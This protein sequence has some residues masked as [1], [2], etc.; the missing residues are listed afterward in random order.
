[1]ESLVDITY[2]ICTLLMRL[3]FTLLIVRHDKVSAWCL[4]QDMLRKMG[5]WMV[6]RARNIKLRTFSFFFFFPILALFNF[7]QK[8]FW[9]MIQSGSQT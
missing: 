6:W 9:Q 2:V 7:D 4:V 5:A 3:K 1:M 8:F